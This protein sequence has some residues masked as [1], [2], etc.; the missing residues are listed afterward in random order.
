MN[1]YDSRATFERQH[2]NFKTF[3]APNVRENSPPTQSTTLSLSRAR[4]SI[5]SPKDMK[6]NL[7]KQSKKWLR[8]R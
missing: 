6:D 8:H 2:K 3:A 1:D 4:K 5:E 7:R